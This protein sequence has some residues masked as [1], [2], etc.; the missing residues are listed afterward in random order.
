M[1]GSAHAL[2]AL[3]SGPSPLW[4]AT[5]AS[6]T[7][8]LLLLTATVVLGVAAGGRYAPRRI[9]RFEVST[10]HRNLSLLTLAFLG[11]HI[12]TAV[13]DSYASISPLAA[14][15]PF[16]SAYRPLWVGLGAVALDLLLAV[17]ITSALRHRLGRRRWKAVHWLAYGAWPVALFHAVGT[18]TDTR[19]GPQLLLYAGCL[20]AVLAAAGWRLA[21][22][23]TDAG[24]RVRIWA[25]PAMA[26]IP[27]MLTA[28]LAVGPLRPGW[29]HHAGGS[30]PATAPDRPGTSPPATH[31]PPSGGD[32]AEGGDGE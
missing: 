30:V 17:G 27:V 18:G 19:L 12:A 8:S 21:H 31:Q 1:T 22:A 9:A 4:Y 14:I 11:L 16:A 7:V 3:S 29:A 10:L 25:V 23:A 6:G 26:L 32:D 5:R 2:L 20:A 15:V 13:A 24:R 28:F